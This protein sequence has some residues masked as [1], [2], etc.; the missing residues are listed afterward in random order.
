MR[1]L[2]DRQDDVN[3][4][5][6]ELLELS[7]KYKIEIGGCGCCGSPFLT[8]IDDGSPIVKYRVRGDSEDLTLVYEDSE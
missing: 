4:F 6:N 5:L 1:S 3:G 8:G 7:K 2:A